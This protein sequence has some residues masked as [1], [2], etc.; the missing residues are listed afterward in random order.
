MT[1]KDFF[2]DQTFINI[3]GEQIII[4]KEAVIYGGITPRLETQGKSKNLPNKIFAIGRD[5]RNAVIIADSKVSKFHA[6]V[7][8]KDGAVFIRDSNSTNGTYIN[9]KAIEPNKD[10]KLNNKDIIIVGDTKI[11]YYV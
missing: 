8:F 7:T 5:R 9:G 4:R 10:I 1:K 3:P 2:N 6:L 11:T